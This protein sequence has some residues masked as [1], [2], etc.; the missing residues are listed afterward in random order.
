MSPAAR[1]H[2]RPTKV[3]EAQKAVLPHVDPEGPAKLAA[4]GRLAISLRDVS[5]FSESHIFWWQLHLTVGALS[6]DKLTMCAT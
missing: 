2:L 3:P 6:L 5:A 1:Q 4:D